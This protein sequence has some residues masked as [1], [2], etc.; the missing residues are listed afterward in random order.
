MQVR[1][2]L[3]EAVS[4]MLVVVLVLVLMLMLM[5]M[6]QRQSKLGPCLLVQT[7]VF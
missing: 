2:R 7:G 6:L 1:R 3:V 5:P 4:L